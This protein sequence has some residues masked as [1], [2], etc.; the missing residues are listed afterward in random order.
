MQ[1]V[2]MVLAELIAGA[3]LIDEATGRGPETRD[4]AAV[5]LSG[6]K[7]VEGMAAGF[8]VFH[9]PR[10]VVEVAA[11]SALQGGHYRCRH[12]ASQSQSFAA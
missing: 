5:R 12:T 4:G 2:A 1:T 9:Q 3:G 6:L 10:V 8:A 11:D 7:L